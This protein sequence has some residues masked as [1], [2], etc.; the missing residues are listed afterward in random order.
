MKNMF[1]LPTLMT[2]DGLDLGAG[3]SICGEVYPN[4]CEKG[5]DKGCVAGGC[6][7]GAVPK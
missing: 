4:I 3:S 1:E 7:P 5:C 2:L 6:Y